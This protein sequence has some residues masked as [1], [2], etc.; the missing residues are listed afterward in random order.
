MSSTSVRRATRE[1]RGDI[2]ATL[3]SAFANDPVF[4]WTMRTPNP[5]SS[6]LGHLFDALVKVETAK[7][8][9]LVFVTGDS[10][11]VALWQGVDGWKTPSIQMLPAIPGLLR[12]LRFGVARGMRLQAVME[13]SHPT[14]PHY[15]L[16]VLGTHR[17][18]QGTGLGGTVL[19]PMIDRCDAEGLPAYLENSNPKN[20]AFYS[21]HGFADRGHLPMPEGAPPLQAMWREPR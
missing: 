2:T 13:R 15:Y 6:R 9:H 11:S 4:H 20:E 8:D 14:E 5:S 3:A 10:H 1:D 18:F 7:P 17:D 19:T 16:E 12:A 21:R